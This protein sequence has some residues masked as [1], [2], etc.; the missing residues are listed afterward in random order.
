MIPRTVSILKPQG[1]NILLGEIRQCICVYYMIPFL[2]ARWRS[3]L[4]QIFKQSIF[5]L[6]DQ[7]LPYSIL[8]GSKNMFLHWQ[9]FIYK[10][11][12]T[13]LMNRTQFL[14]VNTRA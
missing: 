8:A 7:T 10:V 13:I 14:L 4:I 2:L 3:H 11:Y 6:Q 5:L 1:L 12:S 9:A